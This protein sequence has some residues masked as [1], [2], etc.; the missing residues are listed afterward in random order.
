MRL[1]GPHVGVE[2]VGI[3]PVTVG[4]ALRAEHQV[5]ELGDRQLA[6]A[7]SLEHALLEQEAAGDVYH[8][9]AGVL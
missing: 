8:D 4:L 9:L 7:A 5:A 3:K 1:C 2:R 6:L